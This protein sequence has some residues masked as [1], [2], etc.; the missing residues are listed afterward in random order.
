M[1]AEDISL[2]SRDIFRAMKA[3]IKTIVH[4][5]AILLIGSALSAAYIFRVDHAHAEEV[6]QNFDLM[7]LGDTA[8]DAGFSN[9]SLGNCGHLFVSASTSLSLPYA[10]KSTTNIT[11]LTRMYMT[12]SSTE[13][14]V[15]A[16]LYDNFI[17][18]DRVGIGLWAQPTLSSPDDRG[19]E[20]YMLNGTIRYKLQTS[21]EVSLGAYTV[22]NWYNT[23]IQWQQGTTTYQVQVVVPGVASTGWLNTSIPNASS[24]QLGVGFLVNSPST[25]T[26]NS[27]IDNF[28]FA[29]D[30]NFDPQA[31]A[32]TDSDLYNGS[33]YNTR[34][35]DVDVS[36]SSSST[37]SALVEYYLDTSEYNANNRPDTV[38]V[39]IQK[40]EFLDDDTVL[41][42][43]KLILPLATGEASTTINM[44][45]DFEDGV[46]IADFFFWNINTNSPT[47]S[48]SV[49]TAKFSVS[50]GVVTAVDIVSNYNNVTGSNTAKAQACGITNIGNCIRGLFT[51]AVIPESVDLT[52]MRDL[53]DNMVDYFPFSLAFEIQQ[54]AQNVGISEDT[55]MPTSEL[56]L[57]YVGADFEIL[58]QATVDKFIPDDTRILFRNII[59]WSAWLGF[60]LMVF[61]TC[62][63]IF[64]RATEPESTQAPR[65]HHHYLRGTK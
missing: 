28:Y 20:V 32:S 38:V 29:S 8:C 62:I 43:H 47:F 33:L 16:Q 59:L 55:A 10:L 49:I 18:S 54:K 27:F 63:N 37:V 35:L 64:R 34:F 26:R 22:N 40:E 57:P 4:F 1:A 45:H 3:T 23:S 21:S 61:F 36:G 48:E 2:R 52:G 60:A 31:V 44:Q 51:W 14:I 41:T 11:G 30:D 5:I 50:G 58:S 7:E 6:I 17:G 15:N 9:A 65:E 25:P 24:T 13:G 12:A 42:Q 53:L 56:D 39:A 46:Y 19:I